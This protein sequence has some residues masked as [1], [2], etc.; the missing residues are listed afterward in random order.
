MNTSTST[1]QTHDTTVRVTVIGFLRHCL[2]GAVL[3]AAFVATGFGFVATAHADDI[4]P[5]PSI[6]P[7][8][9]IAPALINPWLSTIDAYRHWGCGFVNWHGPV[10]C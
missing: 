2:A 7:P 3:A 1:N 10:R 8:A 5:P 9:A 4:P 6:D